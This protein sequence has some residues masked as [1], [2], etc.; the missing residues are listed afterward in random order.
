MA[1]LRGTALPLVPLLPEH[2][3]SAHRDHR[4]GA[5]P[6]EADGP[7][8]T[9]GLISQRKTHISQKYA[10]LY[11]E[12]S[13]VFCYYNDSGMLSNKYGIFV[14]SRLVSNRAS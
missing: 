9:P 6:A 5:M 1:R 12:K 10:M 11:L 8:M 7:L 13:V 4:D 3:A 14:V 2:A